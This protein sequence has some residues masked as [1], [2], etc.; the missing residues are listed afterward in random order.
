MASSFRYRA[1]DRSGKVV[2][3]IVEAESS[4]AVLGQ[5]RAQ[6]LIVTKVE[7]VSSTTTMN[8]NF[9]FASL[10][11]KKV[12]TKDLAIFSRQFATMID[13]GVPLLRA[14]NIL[15]VQVENKGLRNALQ[16][17][18]KD[19]E[20]GLTL[21][22][23]MGKHP[24]IFPL[25]YTNMIEAGEVG[26]VLEQVLE[27]MANHFEKED[28]IKEKVKSAL[29]YPTVVFTM[30]ILAIVFMLIFV[31]PSFISIY[32]GMDI[33]LPGITLFV[34]SISD[35]LRIYWY[36]YLGFIISIYMLFK[37]FR[38]AP[39]GK[40]MLDR[41]MLRIPVFGPLQTK[42]IISRFSRTLSTLLR[43][44]VPIIT[45]L[46]VVKKTTDNS[47]MI[48]S[49]DK[50][51]N[52]VRDGQGLA[53]PLKASGVFTPMALHMIAVGE[54]TGELDLLLEKISFFYDRDVDALVSKLSSALEPMI[55]VFM[56]IV[57]GGIVIAFMLPMVKMFS[58]I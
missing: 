38:S 27:R 11:E 12:K 31:L 57:I 40:L 42:L 48:A 22:E 52:N 32:D 35:S 54:E 18:G 14:L 9:N 5:L 26:G 3:G 33:E 58:V 56:G 29:T 34:I 10:N 49:L 55:M 36:L 21:S 43:S 53:E 44:G 8:L 41:L 15:Q 20:K 2:E 51:K 1:R 17:I 16:T 23:A 19:L 30:A 39:R 50:A 25:M 24:K 13:A 47:V 7:S 37:R 6:N 28:E 4:Q 45:A 46:E